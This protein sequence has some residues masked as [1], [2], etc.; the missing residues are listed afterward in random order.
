MHYNI[1]AGRLSI[2]G[3]LL[4]CTSTGRGSD[5]QKSLSSASIPSLLSPFPLS[6]F[7]SIPFPS[8]GPHLNA[9]GSGLWSLASIVACELSSQQVRAETDRQTH[10]GAFWAKKNHAFG[11][12]KS[13]INRLFVSQLQFTNI[14][15]TSKSFIGISVFKSWGVLMS[16]HYGTS[17]S[18]SILVVPSIWYKVISCV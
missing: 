4:Y 6:H 12:I 14:C 15:K 9:I 13:T 7:T 2:W 1:P 16:Y 5:L 18:W 11:D 3:L 8:R 17:L 10:Y